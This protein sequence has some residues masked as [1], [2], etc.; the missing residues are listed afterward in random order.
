[1][2]PQNRFHHWL[3]RQP[4]Q[5]PQ[6]PAARLA[7]LA[8]RV[9]VTW[10]TR[11]DGGLPFRDTY[12]KAVLDTLTAAWVEVEGNVT[13]DVQDAVKEAKSHLVH[14]DTARAWFKAAWRMWLLSLQ[15]TETSN[16]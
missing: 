13:A 11:P 16:D 2:S 4:T 14:E 1:M 5:A 3:L 15:T 7:A 10:P 9:G 12:E 6:G 8:T